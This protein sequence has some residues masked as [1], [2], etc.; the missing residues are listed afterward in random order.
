M[1][2]CFPPPGIEGRR[3]GRVWG[4]CFLF[5]IGSDSMSSGNITRGAASSVAGAHPHQTPI[6]EDFGGVSDFCYSV[7]PI[8]ASHGQLSQSLEQKSVISEIFS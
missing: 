5:F 8:D 6:A 7:N 4:L 3:L 2:C 1:L